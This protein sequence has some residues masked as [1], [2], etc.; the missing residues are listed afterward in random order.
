MP[1][2]SNWVFDFPPTLCGLITIAPPSN[3]MYRRE[4]LASHLI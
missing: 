4:N 3:R 2:S 1:P